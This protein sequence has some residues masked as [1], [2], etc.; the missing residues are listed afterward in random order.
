[1]VLS[2]K[3]TFSY[4]W[5]SRGPPRNRLCRAAGG[6]PLRGRGRSPR[7][8]RRR[9]FGGGS[10]SQDALAPADAARAG[11]HRLQDGTAVDSF[12]KSVVL[13]LVPRQLDGVAL[14]GHIDD[15]AA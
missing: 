10:Y 4:G 2:P 7:G 8:H 9:R 12:Q 11:A 6:A 14:I 3:K 5:T 13:A 15:A 1:M